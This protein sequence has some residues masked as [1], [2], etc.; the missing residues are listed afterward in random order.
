MRPFSLLFMLFLAVPFAEIYVLIEVGRKIGTLAT[1]FLLVFTAVL[2]ALLVRMQGM[3]T[4]AH[5]Q[6]AVNQGRLPATEIIEGV[7]IM[8]AG[9]LLLTPGFVTDAVGFVLLV[10]GARRALILAVL[11]RQRPAPPDNGERLFR[12]ETGKPD[13]TG[14][15]GATSG[16]GGRVIEGE[17]DDD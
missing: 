9:L 12:Q 5:I 6:Q 17:L 10:P 13:Y 1:I 15:E 7:M 8:I 2:G 3:S 11:N 16:S 14:N 4:Y